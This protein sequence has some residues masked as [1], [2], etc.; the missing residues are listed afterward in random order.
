VILPQVGSG[1]AWPRAFIAI[2]GADGRFIVAHCL[3]I[4]ADRCLCGVVVLSFRPRS[5][6]P[7][8]ESS[9]LVALM[10]P[11]FH[12][13]KDRAPWLPPEFDAPAS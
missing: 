7:R 5:L 12:A 13:T 3:S 1:E 2:A 9:D 4:S 11:P 8:T 6:G 10:N